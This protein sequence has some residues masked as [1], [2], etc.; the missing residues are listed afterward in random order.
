MKRL[1]IPAAALGLATPAVSAP[2]QVTV[3]HAASQPSIPASAEHFTGHAQV[4]RRFQAPAPARAGGAFV[5]FDPGAHTDWHS[6]PLGQTLIVTAGAGFVQQ[7]GSPRQTIVS[8]DVVWI[9]PGVKHWYGAAPET[10]LTHLAIT[11]ALDGR[12]VDWMEKVTTEQYKP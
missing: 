10:G 9:P 8:G 4:D 2:Q 5:T 7:W 12:T 6:H 11:E 1:A 3:T